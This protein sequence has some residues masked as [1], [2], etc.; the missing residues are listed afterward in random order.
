MNSG[1]RTTVARIAERV[2]KDIAPGNWTREKLVDIG[3]SII[4]N[5]IRVKTG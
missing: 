5:A 1:E 3:N 2:S 4:Q